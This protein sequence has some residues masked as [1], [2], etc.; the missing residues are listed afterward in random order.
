[1]AGAVGVGVALPPD[2]PWPP[3]DL[4]FSPLAWLSLSTLV[5]SPM[6]AAAPTWACALVPPLAGDDVPPAV[7]VEKVAASA[8]VVTVPP[9]AAAGANAAPLALTRP[10]PFDPP[11][12]PPVVASA[13]PE[14]R[15]EVFGASGSS[16]PGTGRKLRPTLAKRPTMISATA[17]VTPIAEKQAARRRRGNTTGWSKPASCGALRPMFL[18][19]LSMLTREHRPIS[20]VPKALEPEFLILGSDL[21]RELRTESSIR[22]IDRSSGRAV[23]RVSESPFVDPV[24][25][26]HAPVHRFQAGVHVAVRLQYEPRLAVFQVRV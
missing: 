21:S 23:Y 3:P 7:V 5:E 13:W 19:R 22:P 18:R 10:P 15:P 1:V 11:S 14:L 17:V 12:P 4:P 8:S 25:L 26:H 6:P 2:L 16:R 24:L 20:A 9:V